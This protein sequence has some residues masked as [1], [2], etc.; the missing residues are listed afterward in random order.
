MQR[1]A[2]ERRVGRGFAVLMAVLGLQACGGEQPAA[3]QGSEPAQAP[4]AAAPAQV[5]APSGE[6]DAALADQG[7]QLFQTKA[8]VGCHRIGG[9]TLTGPDLQGVT[10]R[11][12]FGWMVAMITNPDSM[13]RADSTARALFAQYAT[14][15]ANM[16]V[17]PDEARALYEY[18]RRESQ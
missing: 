9:G 7:A 14:P 11:R 2:M 13:L 1:R 8:C 16:G 6:I 10:E 17:S 18:L 3:D 5:A 15:M 4:A 12:T